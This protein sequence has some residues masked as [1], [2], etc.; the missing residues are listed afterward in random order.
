MFAGRI[1]KRRINADWI[2]V[3]VIPPAGIR[4]SAARIEHFSVWAENCVAPFG[5]I[6][7]VE[8]NSVDGDS[9]W[10]KRKVCS[11]LGKLRFQRYAKVIILALNGV[12]I[13]FVWILR[14]RVVW[15]SVA[16]DF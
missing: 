11:L 13:I 6:W 14:G 5:V 9:N 3:I 12:G 1:A 15:Y 16:F 2:F 4:M 10:T 7:V 8:R